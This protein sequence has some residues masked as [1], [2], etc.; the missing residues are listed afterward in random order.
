LG[1]QHAS[2]R[3]SL[4]P[5][6]FVV[7][8]FPPSKLTPSSIPAAGKST[9]ETSTMLF[10]FVGLTAIAS[11][12]SFVCRW[13]MSTF[14]GIDGAAGRCAWPEAA[15]RNARQSVKQ[16]ATASRLGRMVSPSPEL[17]QAL[18]LHQR[19]GS[20]WSYSDVGSS[21]ESLGSSASPAGTVTFSGVTSPGM[22]V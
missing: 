9:F 21:G 17:Q 22:N 14:V 3:L 6:S 13:L 1:S 16:N 2:P 7:H 11:S 12:D 15:K 5:I 10:G 18:R 8:V 19:D 4:S 20:G